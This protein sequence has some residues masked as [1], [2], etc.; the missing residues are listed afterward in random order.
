MVSITNLVLYLKGFSKHYFSYFIF[1]GYKV[2]LS[3]FSSIESKKFLKLKQLNV[4]C[5]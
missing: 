3:S 4:Y 5:F 1:S 2:T